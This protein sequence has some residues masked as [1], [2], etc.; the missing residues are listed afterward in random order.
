MTNIYLFLKWININHFSFILK[1]TI[2]INESLSDFHCIGFFKPMSLNYFITKLNHRR[3]NRC[4]CISLQM[5]VR[6]FIDA[7]CI[8]RCMCIYL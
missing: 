4:M 2:F 6:V 8:H 1:V 5:H 7:A 3:I